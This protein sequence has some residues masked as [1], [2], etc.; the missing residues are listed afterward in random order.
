M[1]PKEYAA[2]LIS[3]K[4]WQ[5]VMAG[6]H[7]VAHRTFNVWETLKLIVAV[8]AVKLPALCLITRFEGSLQK[9]MCIS[10]YMKIIFFPYSSVSTLASKSSISKALV[11]SGYYLYSK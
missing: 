10:Q 4:Q 1:Q 6:V 11:P 5:Y 8:T 7:S 2:I 3:V 9:K